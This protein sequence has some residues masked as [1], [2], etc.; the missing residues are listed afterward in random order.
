M[1]LGEHKTPVKLWELAEEIF[2]YNITGVY[3]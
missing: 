1:V 3:P 2:M